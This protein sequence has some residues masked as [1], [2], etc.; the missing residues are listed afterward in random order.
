[1][2][3]SSNSAFFVF[4]ILALQNSPMAAGLPTRHTCKTYGQIRFRSKF[5]QNL[6]EFHSWS[7][8]KGRST[9]VREVGDIDVKSGKNYKTAKRSVPSR[10]A[11][12]GRNPWTLSGHTKAVALRGGWA[13]LDRNRGPR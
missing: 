13:E 10:Y 9:E 3:P 2:N 8:S 4:F 12:S 7:K 5:P 1:M 11:Q 6:T